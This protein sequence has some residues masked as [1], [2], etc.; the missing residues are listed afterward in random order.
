MGLFQALLAAII[1]GGA[2]N[3]AS[4]EPE[5]KSNTTIITTDE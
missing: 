4:P 3:T 2:L 5:S 1:L